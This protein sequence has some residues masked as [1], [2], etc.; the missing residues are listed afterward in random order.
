MIVVERGEGE[1]MRAATLSRSG[2]ADVVAAL[3]VAHYRSLVRMAVLL[4]DSDSCA[5]EVVQDAFV[6]LIRRW[7]ALHD[8][9]AA[10]G[11]LRRTVVNG[12]RDQLR[13]RRVRRLV[14][15]PTVPPVPGADERVMRD[16]THRQLIAALAALPPRQ[17]EVLVLRYYSE[18]SER[19][20]ADCLGVSVGTV[21]S[22]AHRGLAALRTV[23][24]EA[25]R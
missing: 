9:G 21:K 17:R 13:S 18:L 4:V 2:A 12:A 7:W 24:E 22:S 6:K 25:H 1:S 11:Y 15:L 8:V 16:E 14:R 23:L 10:E 19:E 3:H 5:E 20:V